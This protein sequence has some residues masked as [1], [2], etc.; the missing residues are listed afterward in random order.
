MRGTSYG[1]LAVGV[2]LGMLAAVNHFLLRLNPIPHFSIYIGALGGLLFIAGL[3]M[4]F[5]DN[6][7]SA[8]G[9]SGASGSG[10]ASN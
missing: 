10:G 4:T 7:G 2:V 9:A 1:L 6:G 5:M 8:S 3:A